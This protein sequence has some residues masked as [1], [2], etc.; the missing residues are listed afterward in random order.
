VPDAGIITSLQ[1]G[2]SVDDICVGSAVRENDFYFIAI[3]FIYPR[4]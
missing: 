1:Y 3:I 2:R 4:R